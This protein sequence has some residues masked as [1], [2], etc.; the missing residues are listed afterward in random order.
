VVQPAFHPRQRRLIGRLIAPLLAALLL[1]HG[2]AAQ[3]V[4]PGRRLEAGAA[5][6][7]RLV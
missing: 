2:V 6:R 4:F 5:C 1:A 3:A 7:E